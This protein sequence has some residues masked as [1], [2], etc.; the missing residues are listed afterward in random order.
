MQ[1]EQFE[2]VETLVKQLGFFTIIRQTNG[3]ME[4]GK[5][6]MQQVLNPGGR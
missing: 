3:Q 4:E 1:V 2:L 5:S 6:D